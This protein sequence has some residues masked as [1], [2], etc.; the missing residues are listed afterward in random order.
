MTSIPKGIPVCNFESQGNPSRTR[1]LHFETL[2][3]K[4]RGERGHV[5][6]R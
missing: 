6:P 4:E 1:L 2:V 3:G 5:N